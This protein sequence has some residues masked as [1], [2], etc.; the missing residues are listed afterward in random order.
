MRPAV[1]VAQKAGTLL[2]RGAVLRR[3]L[4]GR[5]ETAKDPLKLHYFSARMARAAS[6]PERQAP[7]IFDS[8][9]ASPA[10]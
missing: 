6:R 1:R 7:S 3:T 8:R 5:G 10:K 4:P 2:G 9:N